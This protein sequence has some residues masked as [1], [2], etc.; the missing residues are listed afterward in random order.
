VGLT[1]RFISPSIQACRNRCLTTDVSDMTATTAPSDAVEEL[2]TELNSPASSME[3]LEAIIC[4]PATYLLADVLP[5]KPHMGRPRDYPRFMWI[6]YHQLVNYVWESARR[7]ET[8]LNNELVWRFMR[9]KVTEQ[10]P[11]DPG[12]W[13]PAK[14][15]RRHHY[16]HALTYIREPEIL[17]QM[18]L[19]EREQAIKLAIMIGLFDEGSPASWTHPSRDKFLQADGKVVAPIYKA[20]RGTTVT[21]RETGEIRHVRSDPD[22][23]MH[24]V[25]GG[26]HR[27]GTKFAI[28]SARTQHQR[29]VLDHEYVPAKGDG[30]EAGMAMRCFERLA[31][32]LPGAQGV[33]YD[34][35]MRGTHIDRGMR[36]LGWLILTK[37][38]GTR[39]AQGDPRTWHIE[40]LEIRGN[41]GET[42]T[43][44]IYARDGA[45]G[46]RAVDE[47]GQDIFIP[48]RRAS[49]RRRGAS[50]RYRFYGE[51]FLP[52]DHGGHKVPLRL[53]GNDDDRERGLNRAEHLRA[54]PPSD[55]DFAKLFPRRNDAESLNRHLQD[56]MYWGRAHSVGQ[57]GQDADLLGFGMGLNALT[58]HRH[59]KRSLSPV[60]A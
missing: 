29:V 60:A 35:A 7:V 30:G 41:G 10:F 18:K 28:V 24:T 37:V 2:L 45:P 27:F 25:G 9:N 13:L 46:I 42:I 53:H 44:S 56:T 8:E 57:V 55:A 33:N 59:R 12:M 5:D 19:L 38:H 22:A 43:L 16:T 58:W 17:E 47:T 39:E 51:Y 23:T 54:L 40:D 14:P 26:D 48:L 50:G 6:V 3:K 32:G 34:M 36:E 20:R 11:D 4:C 31:P 21:D 52:E 15:M 49:T 1:A